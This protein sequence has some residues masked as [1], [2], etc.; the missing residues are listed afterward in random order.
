[1]QT[2]AFVGED[3]APAKHD[4][5]CRRN[6]STVALASSP[7]IT[8]ESFSKRLSELLIAIGNKRAS[9]VEECAQFRSCAGALLSNGC[10]D[11][12]PNSS[13]A[14]FAAAL[15]KLRKADQRI[16]VALVGLESRFERSPFSVIAALKAARFGEV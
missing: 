14:K 16:Q 3:P 10:D 15:M 8:L 11:P 13:L 7:E 1:M 4:L 12:P 6:P 9:M 2:E 5:H